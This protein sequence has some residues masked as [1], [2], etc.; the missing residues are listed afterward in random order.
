MRRIVRRRL[1]RR[2]V[3]S[4]NKKKTLSYDAGF[5]RYNPMPESLFQTFAPSAAATRRDVRDL[6][7]GFFLDIVNFMNFARSTAGPERR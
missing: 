6:E 1:R 5:V 7:K 4:Q 3:S 2:L